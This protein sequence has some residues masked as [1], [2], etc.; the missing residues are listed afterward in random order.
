MKD[1]RLAA[2]L[3]N[4]AALALARPLRSA[5][6]IIGRSGRRTGVD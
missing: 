1:R 6:E 5:Q 2:A 4:S 3:F